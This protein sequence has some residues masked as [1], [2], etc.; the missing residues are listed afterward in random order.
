MEESSTL[1]VWPQPEWVK[2]KVSATARKVEDHEEFFAGG[3]PGSQA[4]SWV[5]ERI[6]TRRMVPRRSVDNDEQPRWW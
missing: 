3:E 6:S 4:E 2:V 5:G 1:L